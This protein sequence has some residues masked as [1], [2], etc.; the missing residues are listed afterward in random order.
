MDAR[1]SSAQPRGPD[2]PSADASLSPARTP[3]RDNRPAA[4]VEGYAMGSAAILLVED[5]PLTRGVLVEMLR[6]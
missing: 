4:P 6:S 5:N 3:I 1:R 2:L